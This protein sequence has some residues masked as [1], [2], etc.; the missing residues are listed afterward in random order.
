MTALLEQLQA[1]Q[2]PEL[3]SLVPWTWDD[4]G[5][6]WLQGSGI[7]IPMF[8]A[9]IAVQWWSFRRS[10]GVASSSSACW[11]PAMSSRRGWRV[12]CFWW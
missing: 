5:F 3:L 7:S 11:P 10:D 8:T 6:H 9:Y 2:R 12:G 4:A 1:L